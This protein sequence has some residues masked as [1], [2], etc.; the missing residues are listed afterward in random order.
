MGKERKQKRA[1]QRRPQKKASIFFLLWTIFS[2]FALVMILLFWASQQW[3]V[4]QA[5][6]EEASHEIAEKGKNIEQDILRGTPSHFEGNLSFYL[7]FLADRYGVRIIL[8][9]EE[10]EV[11]FPLEEN[12][13]PSIPELKDY[14]DF[15][16]EMDLM[17]EKLAQSGGESVVYEGDGEY[18]YGAKIALYGDMPVYLYAGESLALAEAAASQMNIRM[19]VLTVFVFVTAFAVASA[20]AGWLTKPIAEITEKARALAE[21]DFQVDFHGADYGEEMV[22]LADALNF[23]RDELSKTDRMQ[24]EL[25]AN[26]SHD[27]KTPLTMIKAYASMIMEIS[28]D[29]PEKRNKH[30]QVIV[31]EADRLTGLVVD[32]L[33]LSKL[34]AGMEE[35]RLSRVDMSAY[36]HEVLGRFAYLKDT[37]GYI[38]EADV[39]EGLYARVDEGKIGQV[40]YNLIGNAVNYT[41]EDKRVFVRLKAEGERFFFSVTDTGAGIKKEGIGEIW[42][43][44]YRSSEAHKR[45]VQGTGL[46]LSIVKT[47]LQRHNL[48]FGV[49]SEEGKGSTFYVAFPF[50]EDDGLL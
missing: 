29:V 19:A 26:V 22:E 6:K 34:R 39:D 36:V 24:K 18:V 15:S 8:L 44:Y 43:R 25:M 50:A 27:F 1:R 23:A 14:F 48:Q 38:F 28:G 49:E 20:V 46:G 31:D 32:M 5:Y 11:L 47:I 40:L 35:L 37:Q 3:Y 30:A 13:D 45:P 2:A 9:S 12:F 7:R 10:G 41:G 17:L 42:D 21:G 16:Q 33:E 4:H